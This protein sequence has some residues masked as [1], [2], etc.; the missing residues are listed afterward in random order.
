MGRAILSFAKA[1]LFTAIQSGAAQKL[2]RMAL[3]KGVLLVHSDDHY[4]PGTL[5]NRCEIAPLL[6]VNDPSVDLEHFDPQPVV[7]EIQERIVVKWSK[8]YMPAARVK[9]V[10]ISYWMSNPSQAGVSRLTEVVQRR[11]GSFLEITTGVLSGSPRWSPEIIA[12]IS[13]V[14]LVLCD[15]TVPRRDVFVEYGVAIGK[16]IPLVQCIE[17]RQKA[18]SIPSWLV[19]RQFQYY[20]DQDLD[21]ERFHTSVAALLDNDPDAKTAWKRDSIGRT[22]EQPVDI[23]TILFISPATT[24]SLRRQLDDLVQEN[25]LL[26]RLQQ[27]DENVDNLEELIKAVRGAGSVILIFDGSKAD[28]LTCVAGGIYA[29]KPKTKSAGTQFERVLLMHEL[30]PNSIPGLL[31]TYPGAHV[32]SNA[33]EVR[34]RLANRLRQINRFLTRRHR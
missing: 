20:A 24:K 19:A 23:R 6:L 12:K 13:S 5:P 26:L 30:K 28:Y 34:N 1:D 25:G 7:L 11:F 17:A 15:L 33:D 18:G 21:T 27:V 22:L 29:A 4:V 9:R 10:F 8:P 14:D 2:L 16:H 32:C 3:K 31:R